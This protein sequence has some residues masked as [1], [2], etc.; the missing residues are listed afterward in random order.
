MEAATASGS[1]KGLSKTGK[2]IHKGSRG[3]TCDW[4]TGCLHE[5]SCRRS[6]ESLNQLL[7]LTASCGRLVIFSGSGLSANSGA[8]LGQPCAFVKH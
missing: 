4:C 8:S 3:M 5:D 2:G 6:D 7:E 1:G